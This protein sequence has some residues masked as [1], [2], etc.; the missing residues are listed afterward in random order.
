M[1]R[2]KLITGI[3]STIILLQCINTGCNKT[4]QTSAFP[5]VKGPPHQRL[6][7]KVENYFT[8]PKV[9]ALCK[10]IETKDLKE[11][12]RIVKSGVDVN[13]K[14]R[15]NMTPL[16]WAFPMG[17]EVFKKVLEMGGDPNIKLTAKV[18][19]ICL[20]EGD[21]VMSASASPE[22]IEG[23]IH[24]QYFYDAPMTN[25]LK[26]VL[27]HRGNPN[28]ED[29]KGETPLFYIKI[30]LPGHLPERIRLLLDAGADINHQ[31]VQGITAVMHAPGHRYDSILALLKNGADYRIKNNFGRDPVIL[32]ESQ[33]M[34]LEKR[35]QEN[36]NDELNKT[37]LTAMQPV[38]DWLA[39]E[40]VNW[41]AARAALSNP[42]IMD[43]IKNLPADCQHRPWLPQRS[44]LKKTETKAEKP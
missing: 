40:G 3:F 37:E 36:P 29:M 42:E 8:D 6:G 26:I 32:C 18:W 13:S 10:A 38:R 24:D 23:P 11:I 28:I 35:F 21:S 17:E 31:N 43:N 20:S 33:K 27:E 12:D 34:I 44:T 25:Y 2:H 15:G 5:Q 7:W 4:Q 30:S 9:L 16:L 1:D 14:G 41:E 22:L 19:T 39:K